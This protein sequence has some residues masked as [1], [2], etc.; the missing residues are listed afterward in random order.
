MLWMLERVYQLS[1]ADKVDDAL[2]VVIN[3]IDSMCHE[4]HFSDI[5]KLLGYVDV[6]RLDPSIAMGF[7]T[8]TYPAREKLQK[9]D[10]YF[11]KLERRLMDTLPPK[12]VEENLRNLR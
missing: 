9:R 10:E 6:E 11:V 1:E 3:L 5:D 4:G 12:E 8:F 7:L 2:D